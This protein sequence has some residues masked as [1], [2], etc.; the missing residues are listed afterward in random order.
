MRKL[1][2][3]D[4]VTIVTIKESMDSGIVAEINFRDT[5]VTDVN[6][7]FAYISESP[8]VPYYKKKR[9]VHRPL[10]GVTSFLLDKDKLTPQKK[11]LVES[12]ASAFTKER[13]DGSYYINNRK[14]KEFFEA[15]ALL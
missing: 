12:Y 3:D 4:E 15:H 13:Y 5:V 6:S 9:E 8:N 14:V 7:I 1:K 11:K 10:Y 2:K